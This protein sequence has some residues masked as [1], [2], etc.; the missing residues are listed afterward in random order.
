MKET[1]ENQANSVIVLQPLREL[2]Y[3]PELEVT[4]MKTFITG[5]ILAGLI[6]AAGCS[7][8]AT[9]PAPAATT[10]HMPGGSGHG[11]A[12]SGHGPGHQGK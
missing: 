7:D 4:N 5:L 3:K 8:N 6:A 11:S 9:Q 1:P 2:V 12:G 10:G